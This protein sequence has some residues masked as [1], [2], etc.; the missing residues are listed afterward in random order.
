MTDIE[1][2]WYTWSDVGL[3]N[4]Q[5]GLRIRAASDGLSQIFSERVKS[6]EP[7]L[8]YFLPP[9]TDYLAATPETAPVTLALLR[10]KWQNEYLL[11]Q[12]VYAGKD[13]FGRRG[14]FFIHLL[15]FSDA[16]HEFSH[17]DAI[18][19]WR[20]NLW[21][22]TDMGLDRRSNSLNTIRLEDIYQYQSFAPHYLLVRD[23]LAFLIEAYLT[24]KDA[25]RLYIAVPADK[26][27]MIATLI[28]GL[29]LSLPEQLL[30]D[31]T[32]STYEPDITQAT[33]QIVGTS[34][35]PVPGKEVD[36]H[37]FA[38]QFYDEQLALNC[39]TNEKSTL[40]NHPQVVSQPHAAEFARFAAQYLAS[41]DRKPLIILRNQAEKDPRLTSEDFLRLYRD[42]FGISNQSSTETIL[43]YLDNPAFRLD[44]LRDSNFRQAV[45]N[46]A[47]DPQQQELWPR[48]R[49][50]LLKLREQS[51]RELQARP[52]G[53][54]AY[55]PSMV[56]QQ[57]T[58]QGR[59]KQGRKQRAAEAITHEVR[60][61]T[62]AAD[63][64]RQLATSA[65][66]VII[67]TLIKASSPVVQN[68]SHD[69][70][71]QNKLRVITTLLD[72]MDICLLPE[73]HLVWKNLLGSITSNTQICTFLIANP[74][75][76]IEFL[77][78]WGGALPAST[79]YDQAIKPLLMI[80]W[81]YLGKFLQLPAIIQHRVWITILLE[82][83]VNGRP[84]PDKQS[85]EYLA[86]NYAREINDLLSLL[87]KEPRT[88]STTTSFVI[89]LITYGYAGNQRFKDI[90]GTLFEQ[91]M[92][93]TNWS[94]A[95]QLVIALISH[96]YKVN[97]T[98]IESL[99]YQL[100]HNGATDDGMTLFKLSIAHR[101]PNRQNLVALWL[102]MPKGWTKLQDIIALA[103]PTPNEKYLFFCTEGEKYLRE[104]AQEMLQLYMELDFSPDKTK[105]LLV[106]LSAPNLE[107]QLQVLDRV[108]FQTNL[109][110]D[111]YAE[112]IRQHGKSY[113]GA[114]SH[115]P[116]LADWTIKIFTWLV[117]HQYAGQTELLLSIFT[118]QAPYMYLENLLKFAVLN[119]AEQKEFLERHGANYIRLMQQ[120]G[121][122]SHCLK[123]YVTNY[124]PM[125]EIED[126]ERKET[127]SFFNTL[128]QFYPSL[129]LDSSVR[130]DIEDWKT[131]NHYWLNPLIEEQSRNKLIAALIRLHL[132]D[133]P[134]LRERF[135]RA[136]VSAGISDRNVLL[137]L[138]HQLKQYLKIDGLQLLYAIAQQYGRDYRNLLNEN[139][140]VLYISFIISTAIPAEL[141]ITK[142]QQDHL[143]LSFLD[144]LLANIDVQDL[145]TWRRLNKAIVAEDR[146]DDALQRW[147]TYLQGLDLLDKLDTDEAGSTGMAVQPHPTA[148]S[149][150][151]HPLAPSKLSGLLKRGRQWIARVQ[152]KGTNAPSPGVPEPPTTPRVRLS[153]PDAY[154]IHAEGPENKK[155]RSK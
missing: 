144:P 143:V 1:Q 148:V 3:S 98:L 153:K 81:S 84:T 83:L 45:I 59:R 87:V 57:S 52:S 99:L 69:A 36:I 37:I 8:H 46:L 34:W 125:L 63:T 141:A 40:T 136:I 24:R 60:Q 89:T 137:G 112:V 42:E 78:C 32:F 149:P 109:E 2:L 122:Q 20:S 58:T 54:L 30:A 49:A 72:L 134:A 106:L 146:S 145:T 12:K 35:I 140:Q 152:S 50:L 114:S 41:N 123:V 85:V 71:Q 93:T 82:N 92:H 88:L 108:C 73:S 39:A 119:N 77:R 70:T 55:P 51:Q 133:S 107:Y 48:L 19:L 101:L 44:K 33:T 121:Q 120:S 139:L 117:Q 154:Q 25:A 17:E 127:T 74:E 26:M 28:A 62:T 124:V 116:R 16:F 38:R 118:T 94:Q 22:R 130:E 5:A 79:E 9:G 129:G 86:H 27:D 97:P 18:F 66:D 103:Y 110:I 15:A 113:L 96:Q 102:N 91:L 142:E 115:I 104:H 10:S 65:S 47:A 147:R 53:S 95:Q 31:L 155:H 132:P 128:L 4:V 13:A 76:L 43:Y 61:Q 56:E 14:N 131:I 100:L 80:P 111:G 11:I 150:G 105:P 29:T 126:F 75:W 138:I 21:K 7:Y 23:Q 135:A 67:N 90:V 64:L 68:V 151:G 6:T